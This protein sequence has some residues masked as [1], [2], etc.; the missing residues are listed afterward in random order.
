[1]EGSRSSSPSRA[2]IFKRGEGGRSLPLRSFVSR[3]ASLLHLCILVLT[4]P[5]LLS[6]PRRL[7]GSFLDV[8]LGDEKRSS[9][10]SK[11]EDRRFKGHFLFSFS[12]LI[13]LYF[14]SLTSLHDQY[15][16]C[17]QDLRVAP[18]LS[19]M[20]AMRGS[21]QQSDPVKESTLLP[22]FPFFCI[23]SLVSFLVVAL[24]PLCP[25]SSVPPFF[26]FC[27]SNLRLA[28]SFSLHWS[29]NTI[30]LCVIR[31]RG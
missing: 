7:P 10:E 31:A 18:I 28:R 12:S 16:R 8:C 15:V 3:L 25:S 5:F 20:G 6:F 19:G 2:S 21:D 26:S 9:K 30:R 27:Q 17:C 22:S 11:L 4:L 23:F 29:S 1:M 24:S 14:P 13:C